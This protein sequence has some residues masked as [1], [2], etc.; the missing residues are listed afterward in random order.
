MLFV[1]F[2]MILFI[3]HNGFLKRK[4]LPVVAYFKAYIVSFII[5]FLIDMLWLGIVAKS[6]YENQIGHLLKESFNFPVALGF[7]LIF[8]V[9]LFFFVINRA[10]IINS[11]QYSLFVGIFF[12][13]ITYGTYDLTN[14]VTLQDWPLKIVFVDILWGGFLCGVTSL[15]SFQIIKILNIFK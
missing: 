10:V 8:V 7:Y 9:G 15:I 3:Y 14:L 4:E 11:W 2:K 13:F 12:G 6:F 1:K 5:F